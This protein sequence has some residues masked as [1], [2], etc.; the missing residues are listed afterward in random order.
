VRVYNDFDSFHV[1]CAIATT[2]Q[3]GE[4]IIYHA[5]EPYQ[6]RNWKS[7]DAAIPGMVKWL[8]MAAGYGHLNYKH[9]NWQPMQVDRGTTV[10]M[11]KA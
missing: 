10:E 4:V 2:V 1:Q 8:H 7:Y 5:F 3:P 9:W 6:F 11:E